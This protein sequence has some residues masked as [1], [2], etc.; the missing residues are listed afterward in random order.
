MSVNRN[1]K[2]SLKAYDVLFTQPVTASGLGKSE[3]DSII[4]SAIVNDSGETLVL[5]RFGDPRWDLRPFFDQ[6]NVGESGKFVAGIRAF[7]LS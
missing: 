5:S 3:R 1:S 4:I 6:S 7:Q 2:A